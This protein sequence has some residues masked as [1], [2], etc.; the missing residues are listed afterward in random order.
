MFLQINTFQCVLAVS[1]S[2]VFL[3]YLYADDLIQWTTSDIDGGINGIGGK[4]ARIGFIWKYNN[5]M[6]LI[7]GSETCSIIE[8]TSRSNINIPGVFVLAANGTYPV[9]GEEYDTLSMC[10]VCHVLCSGS[11]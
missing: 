11:L 9:F 5:N 3:I 1:G 2:E 4:S 6:Y 7:P 8:V 10:N